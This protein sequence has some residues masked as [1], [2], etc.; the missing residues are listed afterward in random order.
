MKI[1]AGGVLSAAM[2]FQEYI[3][4]SSNEDMSHYNYPSFM[5]TTFIIYVYFMKFMNWDH[6]FY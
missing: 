5:Y 3:N 6:C 2:K 1:H 4:C